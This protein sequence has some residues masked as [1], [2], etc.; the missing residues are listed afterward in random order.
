M[1]SKG[2]DANGVEAHQADV[3]QGRGQFAR[4]V[5]LRDAARKHGVAAIQQ[6]PNRNARLHLEH[7]KEQLF[8]TQVSAPVDGAQIVAVME[9]AMIE[10]LLARTGEM[11]NVVTADQTGEGLLPANRQPLE[12]LEQRAVDQWLRFHFVARVEALSIICGRMV[13]AVWPSAWASKFKMMRCRRTSGAISRISSVLRLSRPRMNA[14]TRPHSTR[15]CAPR[16]ELP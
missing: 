14:R 1:F 11:R 15:A 10:K 12:F 5:K 13:S 2:L 7:F 8:Q 16:G 4:I 3:A 6:N 9:L